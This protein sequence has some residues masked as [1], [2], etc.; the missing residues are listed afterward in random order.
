[1]RAASPAVIAAVV[2]CCTAGQA[3]RAAVLQASDEIVAQAA[4]SFHDLTL[5]DADSSG[6]RRWGVWSVGAP[7]SSKVELALFR[8]DEGRATPVWRKEWPNGYAPT[9]RLTPE[10]TAKGQPLIAVTFQYGAAAEELSL[11]TLDAKGQPT[12]LLEKLSSLANWTTS[13]NGDLLL[14]LYDRPA[15][16][17]VPSCFAW[18]DRTAALHP[19]ACPR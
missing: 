18:D 9:L 11:Y 7:G 14:T 15:S 1:M 17:L 2:T 8:T 6:A 12:L 4:A 3:V 10:W 16:A 19:T 13:A 5:V